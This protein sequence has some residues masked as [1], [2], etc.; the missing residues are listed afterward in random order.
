MD[1]F[2]PHQNDEEPNPLFPI[3]VS[4]TPNGTL[5]KIT[6]FT[7]VSIDINKHLNVGV[8]TI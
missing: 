8:F 2:S 6:P 3:N 5:I 4:D 1:V 7:Q